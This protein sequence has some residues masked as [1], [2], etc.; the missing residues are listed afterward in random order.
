MRSVRRKGIAC[1]D[2]NSH[3]H[4]KRATSRLRL[5]QSWSKLMPTEQGAKYSVSHSSLREVFG[6]HIA[7]FQCQIVEN[8]RSDVGQMYVCSRAPH[9]P[10]PLV[11]PPPPRPA[12]G[13][14][15]P[16]VQPERTHANQREGGRWR[17]IHDTFKTETAFAPNEYC[18]SPESVDWTGRANL[19][20][21]DCTQSE[22][23]HNF[24]RLQDD[25]R[26]VPAKLLARRGVV[27]WR[28]G[29]PPTRRCTW[30]MSRF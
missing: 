29:L 23:W 11:F 16:A 28:R 9:P 26:N 21:P 30:F 4:R 24:T 25:N 2:V 13:P 6:N 3:S 22:S 1:A 17:M 27:D 18:P 10:P 14:L 19:Q 15:L 8:D 7:C 20:L 5:M 12:S